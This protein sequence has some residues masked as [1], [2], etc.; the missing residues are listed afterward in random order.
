M[1]MLAP[2]NPGMAAFISQITGC[3][4]SKQSPGRRR[5]SLST[6]YNAATSLSYSQ[7]QHHPFREN[8]SGQQHIFME[9]MRNDG[10]QGVMWWWNIFLMMCKIFLH[11]VVCCVWPMGG[12]RQRVIIWLKGRK[13]WN[14][15]VTN[16]TYLPLELIVQRLYNLFCDFISWN[17]TGKTSETLGAMHKQRQQFPH[18]WEI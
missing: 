18:V 8:L 6:T 11:K 3:L 4:P 1:S 7:T 17:I 9:R 5:L 16:F 14:V 2:S 13:I 12:E 10:G 15:L